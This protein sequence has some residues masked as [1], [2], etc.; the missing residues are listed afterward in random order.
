MCWISTIYHRSYGMAYQWSQY[1]RQVSVLYRVMHNHRI[2]VF[3]IFNRVWIIKLPQ[4]KDIFCITRNCL[5]NGI[6]FSEWGVLYYALLLVSMEKI[7]LWKNVRV[8]DWT[9]ER[10]IIALTT[11]EFTSFQY[12]LKRGT[13]FWRVT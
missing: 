12:L 3:T 10:V 6:L 1:Q 4:L 5:Q 9:A 7:A 11:L 13:S 2:T 8:N